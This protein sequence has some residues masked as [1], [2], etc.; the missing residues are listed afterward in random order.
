MS[1]TVVDNVLTFSIQV[2]YLVVIAVIFVLLTLYN[3]RK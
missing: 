1:L 3:K 2:S